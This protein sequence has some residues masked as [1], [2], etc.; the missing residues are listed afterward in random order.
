MNKRG[1]YFISAESSFIPLIKKYQDKIPNLNE[2]T[3]HKI[4]ST[5]REVPVHVIFSKN[6]TKFEKYAPL[7]FETIKK[8]YSKVDIDERIKYHKEKSK[9]SKK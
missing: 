7:W 8:Y 9:K 4:F 5:Q 1:D 6:D 2:D 3:F